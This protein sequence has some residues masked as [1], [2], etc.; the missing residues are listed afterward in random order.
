MI[1]PCNIGN[2][3]GT[4]L[5]TCQQ[6]ILIIQ[7]KKIEIYCVISLVHEV[8]DPCLFLEA[9]LQRLALV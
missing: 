2:S 6:Q 4:D 1:I 7:Q 9:S 5:Q 3:K 8:V